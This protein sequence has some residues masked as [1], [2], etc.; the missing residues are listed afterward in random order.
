LANGANMPYLQDGMAR[1]EPL[2]GPDHLP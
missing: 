1:A 2:E